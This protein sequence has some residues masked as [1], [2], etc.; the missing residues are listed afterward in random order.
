MLPFTYSVL[1]PHALS[2]FDSSGYTLIAKAFLPP[3]KFILAASQIKLLEDAQATSLA[4]VILK[5]HVSLDFC[6]RDDG[7]VIS[8]ILLS[9]TVL[10]LCFACARRLFCSTVKTSSAFCRSPE[11]TTI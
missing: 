10:S 3:G 4:F 9:I 11:A 8:S 2:P 6:G 1:L 7:S 5:C